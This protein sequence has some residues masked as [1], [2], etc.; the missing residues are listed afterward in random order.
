M[1]GWL[2]ILAG[3][4]CLCSTSGIIVVISNG[5]YADPNQWED[6]G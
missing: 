6:E 5:T 4:K 2:P 1:Y 3:E